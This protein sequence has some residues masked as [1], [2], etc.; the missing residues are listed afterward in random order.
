MSKPKL[1]VIFG[2][3]LLIALLMRG[4]LVISAFALPNAPPCCSDQFLRYYTAAHNLIQGNGFSK[5]REPPYRPDSFEQPGYIGF[6]AVV[7]GIT[8]ESRK[9]LTLIQLALE[10]LTVLLAYKISRQLGLS[11]L[12][13]TAVGLL[14]P[15]LAFWLMQVMTEVLATFA[16]ALAMWALVKAAA[17]DNLKRWAVSGLA[18]GACLLTRPDTVIAVGFMILA[19]LLCTLGRVSK[20]RLVYGFLTL[21]CTLGLTLTPWTLRGYLLFGAIRP[22]GEVTQLPFGYAKWLNTWADAPP[23]I[24]QYWWPA[25]VQVRDK[26]PF[27]ADKVTDPTELQRAEAAYAQAQQAGTFA[28]QPSGTFSA[29]AN[30]AYSRRPF[31]TILVVPLRRVFV[32]WGYVAQT[33]G[34][35]A[36]AVRAGLFWLGLSLLTLAGLMLAFLRRQRLMLIPLALILGRLALPLIS[37]P[38]SEAR[39]LIETLPAC[40]IFAGLTLEYLGFRAFAKSG[41]NFEKARN[42]TRI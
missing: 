26:K 2:A 42:R 23:Y 20:R 15:F 16:L 13:A 24:N 9:A 4:F 25:L 18:C 5:D 34:H 27:P 37:L 10:L 6:L 3:I 21:I 31:H 40:Y 22:L 32:T 1:S 38:T 36:I 7:Y 41:R 39:F 29:L 11:G 19:G 8:G 30:E 12:G 14:C 35:P 28:G 33:Q 17:D